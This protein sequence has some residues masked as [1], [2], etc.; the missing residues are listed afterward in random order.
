[1]KGIITQ[2]QKV[3]WRLPGAEA[4]G[5]YC[6]MATEFQFQGERVLEMASSDGSTKL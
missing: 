6:L 4:I 2:R 1:M 5:S 3:E